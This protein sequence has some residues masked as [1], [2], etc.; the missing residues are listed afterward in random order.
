MVQFLRAQKVHRLPALVKLHS[1][2]VVTVLMV[3][4]CNILSVWYIRVVSVI[5]CLNKVLN[6]LFSQRLVHHSTSTNRLTTC[7]QLEQ[8]REKYTRYVSRISCR[9]CSHMA[10]SK[11][12]ARFCSLVNVTC[13]KHC[14]ESCV[15]ANLV[16]A[17]R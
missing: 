11:E 16:S 4:E 8:R 2:I 12:K 6:V 14:L 17:P 13:L 3:K 7:S 10:K 5:T 9:F 15:R 1:N